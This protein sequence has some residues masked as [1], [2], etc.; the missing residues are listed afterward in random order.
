MRPRGTSPLE[1][2]LAASK[3]LDRLYPGTR[4]FATWG[5]RS[6]PTVPP[7]TIYVEQRGKI[8]GEITNLQP[9]WDPLWR[10][11]L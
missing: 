4:A 3:T 7:D 5:V 10:E 11:I 9:A 1:A 2:L 6:D 8:V